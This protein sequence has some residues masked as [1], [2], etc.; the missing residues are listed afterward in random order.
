M[1]YVG[2]NAMVAL[3]GT[4]L[5]GQLV[6]FGKQLL[7]GWGCDKSYSTSRYRATQKRNATE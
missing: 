3:F 1:Y 5:D 2:I 6:P 7:G 4:L